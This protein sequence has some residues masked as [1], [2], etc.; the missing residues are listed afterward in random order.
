ME[1][2][3]LTFREKLGDMLMSSGLISLGLVA[4]SV[5]AIVGRFIGSYLIYF[6]AAGEYPTGPGLALF[7]AILL[8][9]L[10]GIAL[11]RLS[12]YTVKK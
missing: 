1:K 3:I 8:L 4:F 9:S 2:Q 5:V 10:F 6:F 7:R 11:I 12:F